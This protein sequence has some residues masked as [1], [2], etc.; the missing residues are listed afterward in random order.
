LLPC[1]DAGRA[2]ALAANV[3]RIAD[4]MRAALDAFDAALPM[5]KTMRDTAEHFDDYALDRGRKDDV[6]RKSLEVGVVGATTFQWLGMELDSDKALD[7]AQRLFST[8]K[9]AKAKWPD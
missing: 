8:I 5:L 1:P 7:A 9:A 4:D 6:S 3:D 2:A